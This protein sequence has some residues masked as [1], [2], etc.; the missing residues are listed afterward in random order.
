MCPLPIRGTH[1]G[2][3]FSSHIASVRMAEPL[4]LVPFLQRTVTRHDFAQHSNLFPGSSP[5][6]DT[7]IVCGLGI[8]QTARIKDTDLSFLHWF[9][10]SRSNI[11]RGW[12][13]PWAM[14]SLDLTKPL[15][16]NLHH[17]TSGENDM[18][19]QEAGKD[20]KKPQKCL[21]VGSPPLVFKLPLLTGYG[22]TLSK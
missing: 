5:G 11:L 8:P 16:S 9:L 7:A 14:S 10:M 3:N 15:L 4:R 17:Q 12:R 2:T 21:G 1:W 20:I 22:Y 13:G 18:E 19:T 6:V